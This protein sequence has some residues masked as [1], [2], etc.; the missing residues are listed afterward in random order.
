LA[1]IPGSPFAAGRNPLSIAVDPSGKFVYAGNWDSSDVSA[2]TID[3]DTGALR[4][5][6]GSPFV[7]GAGPSAV[8]VDPAGK[9]VYV[10]NYWS[11]DISGFSYSSATGA[12]SELASSSYAVTAG[13]HP[14]SIV[15]IRIE[16]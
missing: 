2:Y 13:A 12:L 16:Q 11:D 10:T 5:V 6:S 15:I 1:V 3:A 9:Y 4:T 7:A 14:S 8:A